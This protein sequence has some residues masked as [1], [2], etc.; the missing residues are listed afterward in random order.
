MHNKQHSPGNKVISVLKQMV[1]DR[2]ID[3]NSFDAYRKTNILICCSIIKLEDFA[4]IGF[5]QKIVE[6]ELSILNN[7]Q[8]VNL[9]RISIIYVK[10]FDG[11]MVDLHLELVKRLNYLD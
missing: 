8:L 1:L 3:L 11:F 9:A 4:F 10:E 2:E 7:E 5:F 6:E